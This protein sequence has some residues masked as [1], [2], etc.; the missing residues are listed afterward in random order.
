MNVSGRVGVLLGQQLMRNDQ[1]AAGLIE[2]LQIHEGFVSC[3]CEADRDD[4]T[5]VYLDDQLDYLPTMQRIMDRKAG[6]VGKWPR[7][8]IE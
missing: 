2:F 8:D 3:W 7:T 5:A 1:R 4:L 6:Q